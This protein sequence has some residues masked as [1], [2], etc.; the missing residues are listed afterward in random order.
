MHISIYLLYIYMTIMHM[1]HVPYKSPQVVDG[2]TVKVEN[3]QYTTMIKAR[4]LLR[5][6]GMPGLIIITCYTLC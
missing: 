6:A 2:T 1:C 5:P 4:D 3:M